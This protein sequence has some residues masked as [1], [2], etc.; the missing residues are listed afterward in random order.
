MQIKFF[1]TLLVGIISITAFSGCSKQSNLAT[2]SSHPRDLIRID[3]GVEVPT[4]DPALSEDTTSTRIAY[5]LFAGLVDFDQSNN[6]IPGMATSWDKSNDGKTYTFHLRSG[7]KFSDGSPITAN[8]FVY[9]WR[10]LV[11]P[12]VASPYNMLISNIINARAIIDAK[13]NPTS[14]GVYAPDKLTFV[15]NLVHPDDDFIK[16]I[17][18]PNTMVVSQKVI[19]KFGR[20]WTDP[21]NIVTSGAY[22]L[23]EHVVN[24]YILAEKNPN[25][26]DATNVN[27]PQVKYLPYEEK[28]ASIPAYRS[29]ELDV[30]F[31][32]VPIDQFSQLKKDYPEELHTF[33]QEA[34][35]YYDFSWNNPDLAKN[36]KLRQALS[37]AIDRKVL[38]RDVLKMEQEPMYS[39]AT[40]TVEDGRFKAM[41]YDWSSWSREAQV[42]TAKKLYAEAGYNSTHP[43]EITITYNTN[44]L[45]KKTALA[46]AS[47]W[48]SVL[49]V[50]TNLQN[51]EWKT[52]IQTRHKGNYQI[53]RDGWVADYNSITTYTNLYQC[54]NEQNNSHYCNHE[55]DKLV[56]QAKA[57]KNPLVDKTNLYREALKIPLNDY[58]TIP[59]FQYTVQV[60]VKPYVTGYTPETNHL[61][62]VQTKWM[63]LK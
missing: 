39:T 21:K 56:A 50:N 58:A 37:M 53:A 47:M 61:Y 8:D 57:E 9:S 55:F 33:L 18:L 42:S 11:D 46:I 19:E 63:S 30:T 43:Y 34:V 40:H 41:D 60:L 20:A 26:W 45:H 62:H 12:R 59:L 28:N 16:Q 48:K 54:G 49:G 7:L 51:E 24:G 35:Y 14:L 6:V 17:S 5:D 31:Q 36:A 27:I 2:N 25:F 52:F 32:G 15:V 23:K 29:G 10:R 13:Q 3:V 38:A 44:D 1:V 22:T 4:L